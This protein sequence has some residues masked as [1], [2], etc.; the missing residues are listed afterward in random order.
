MAQR[1]Q[2]EVRM[3]DLIHQHS[4]L[5][6]VTLSLGVVSRVPTSDQGQSELI[7][8]ADR[9]LYCAKKEGRNRISH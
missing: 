7:A 5:G 2:E 6:R 8:E 4:S 9:L 3:L 1:V